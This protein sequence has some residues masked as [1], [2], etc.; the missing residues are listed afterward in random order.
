MREADIEDLGISVGGQNITNL[1]YADDTALLA[2]NITSM[3]RILHRTDIAGRRA[4]LN[5]N[6]KKT[7]VM[8]IN[9]MENQSNIRV[10]GTN[11]ENVD[12]FKY[13]GSIKSSDGT[14]T[15]DINVRIGM[16][17]QRMVQL[18]NIWKD[19]SIPTS[20]K[21]KILRCLV[22]SV[23]LYGCEAWTTRK[24]EEKKIEAAEMWFYRRLLR[25]SWTE[26]RTN[27]SILEQLGVSKVLTS[28][29]RK[30]K[31]TYLG[32]AMRNKNTHLMKTIFQGKIECGRKR[33][34]PAAS[35][36]KSTTE[37]YGTG[38]QEMSWRCEDREGWRATVRAACR[39]ANIDNDEADR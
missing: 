19:R 39:A 30:R 13:L 33:G 15:D 1:R 32:H 18:N 21:L 37:A 22:W 23:M 29:I 9:T 4:G 34:R 3:R 26:R 10:D 38:L 25:V 36:I 24:K 12:H 16:A 20:L 6:A 2:T 11:L 5:L 7:K 31:L 35:Y 27:E 8:H 17:K 28:L 14:C